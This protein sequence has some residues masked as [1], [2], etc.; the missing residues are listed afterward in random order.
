VAQTGGEVVVRD[1]GSTNG[2]RINGSPVTFGRLKH[3]DTL[4]IAHLVFRLD[5]RAGA[6][7]RLQRDRPP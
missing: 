4:A 3:G 5:T 7:V 1:L 2:V 6:E